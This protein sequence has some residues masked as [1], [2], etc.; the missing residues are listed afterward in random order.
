MSAALDRRMTC[1]PRTNDFD[2]T[3]HYPSRVTHRPATRDRVD[4][5]VWG[6]APGPLS[7]EPLSAEQVR[8]FDADGFL[9]LPGW[10]PSA[11]CRSLDDAIAAVRAAAERGEPPDDLRLTFEMAPEG[12][13]DAH[14]LRTIWSPH[15]HPRLADLHREPRLLGAAQQLLGGDV[16]I[17]QSRVN[18]QRPLR[19]QG[20]YWHQDFEAWHCEDGMPRPRA[21]SALVLLEP[22]R[23]YNGA[24]MVVPGSH[25]RLL[26]TRGPTPPRNWERSLSDPRIGFGAVPD[27][28]LSEAIREGGITYCEGEAGAVV[29][30]DS[31]LLHG[32]HDNIS[33][34][35]RGSVFF[36]FNSVHNRLRAPYAAPGPRPEHL[37][38]RDPATTAALR[39]G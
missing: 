10:M 39:A 31:L 30:F 7:A 25:R 28:L 18:L 8:R 1:P 17:H 33:P 27:D 5:V 38:A 22:A 3:D 20:F 6:D 19:G 24:L 37:A 32:S 15:R 23:P 29:L 35:G 16:Y 9:I 34:F 11:R 14:T 36:V 4:P 13:G 21:L 12:S 2:D 26:Q